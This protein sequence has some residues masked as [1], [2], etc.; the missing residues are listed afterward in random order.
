MRSSSAWTAKKS[1]FPDPLSWHLFAAARMVR[2]LGM[3][4]KSSGQLMA[5]RF[6]L[7][8]RI[9]EMAAFSEDSLNGTAFCI[10]WVRRSESGHLVARLVLIFG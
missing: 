6:W 10:G 4:N 3:K 5:S 1:F 2:C 9:A 8:A 7:F